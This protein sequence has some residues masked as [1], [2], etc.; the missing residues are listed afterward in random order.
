MGRLGRYRNLFG[1][2][3]LNLNGSFS[4]RRKFRIISNTFLVFAAPEIAC[5]TPNILSGNRYGG[6]LHVATGVYQSLRRVLKSDIE[7][8]IFRFLMG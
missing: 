7:R 2:I 8:A 3:R 6:E 1:I 5:I 4:E